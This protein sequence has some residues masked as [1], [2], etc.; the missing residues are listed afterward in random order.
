[1]PPA[2]RL[3]KQIDRRALLAL[4]RDLVRIPTENPPGNERRA[5]LFLEPPLRTLGFCTRRVLS[6]RG[7]WNL[8]AERGFGPA[9]RGARGRSRTFLFNGHLD[10]VPAGDPRAW[11][12]PP[13]GGRVTRG[14]LWGRGAADMKGGIAAFLAA[15]SAVVRSGVRSPHR[16]ALQLV[17]DE[18][19]LGGEG[20]GFLTARYRVRADLAVVGEPTGLRPTLAAKGTLGGFIHVIGRA[21]HAGT[22]ELGLNAIL[23]AARVVQSLTGM[24]LAGRHPLL[25]RP[26]LNVG[27]I[28]GG[29]RAN[30]V[31]PRCT[32]GFDR[33]ILP[34]E[35]QTQ[36]RREI[37]R[38]VAGIRRASPGLRAKLEI[39]PFAEPSEIPGDAEVVRLADEAFRALEGRRP[40]HAG[41]EGTTDARFLIRA[42]IPTLILGPGDLAQAHT[43]DEF[44]AVKELERAARIYAAMLISFLETP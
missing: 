17:S 30:V 15:L 10:V 38:I 44:V 23:H 3:R 33:R 34:G 7:R 12:H 42:G 11:V 4:A 13:Y 26:T 27:T 8:L 40:R 28:A 24:K 43:I 39:G 22:P 16:V 20:T 14:R 19:A 25:G 18:E 41:I 5:V 1:M 36:V 29:L 35:T 32:L 37:A 21:A 2:Q 6:P 9:R 31:P